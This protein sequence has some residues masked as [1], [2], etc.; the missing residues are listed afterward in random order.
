MESA[1]NA[2]IRQQIKDSYELKQDIFNNDNIRSLISE[3][4]MKI[5]ATLSNEGKVIIAGNG[6]SAS[7]SQHIAGEFVSRFFMD[8]DALAAVALT[9]DTSVITAIGNDYGFDRIFS[10]QIQSIGNHGD[11]FIAISTSGNSENIIKALKKCKEK[12]LLQ[13]G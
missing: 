9:T 4:F 12:K 3:I 1:I 10:R 5:V 11:I 13:L 6:G 2:Y 7:D 8:R